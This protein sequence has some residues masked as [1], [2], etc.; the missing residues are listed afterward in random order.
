MFGQ[1]TF[2][3]LFVS[4]VTVI[5]TIAL[6]LYPLPS[7]AGEVYTYTNEKGVIVV[8]NT[9]VEGNAA[10]QAKK[11]GSYKDITDDDRKLWQKEKDDAMQAWREE[12]ARQGETTKQRPDT[13]EKV[14]PEND[15]RE[16]LKKSQEETGRYADSVKQSQKK[17]A[18]VLDT[19]K[20]LR[21]FP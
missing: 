8:T 19:L 21:T 1:K 6:T 12:Q 3:L 16:K 13:T 17:A 20:P 11:I 10:K 18:D 5:W 15:L 9:P 2:Y 4:A 14:L 7:E